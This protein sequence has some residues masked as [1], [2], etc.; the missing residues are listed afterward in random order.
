MADLLLN[1]STMKNLQLGV[2]II[3]LGAT[4][5]Q[6]SAFAAT[7]QTMSAHAN[8]N[9]RQCHLKTTSTESYLTATN[10]DCLDCHSSQ[11]SSQPDGMG[12][13]GN[14]A[15][16]RCLQC[17]SYHESG[18]VI[19]TRGS[20]DLAALKQIDTGHCRSCHNAGSSLQ[21]LS[22]AHLAA[23]TLYHEQAATLREISPSQ[24]CLNCHSNT[25]ATVWQLACDSNVLEFS[26]HSTHPIEVEVI[27]GQGEYA[28]RIRYEIDERVP[29]FDQTIQC[30][31]CHQL[32]S[33]TTD[34]LVN[35]GQPKDLCLGCHQF[36]NQPANQSDQLMATMVT[37]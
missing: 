36:Q 7:D 27:P 9:C 13:H 28:H 4:V 20:I 1:Q 5:A 23:A 34:L 10:S 22:D 8:P 25:S 2:I 3:L 18:V 24:A 21:S 29:L 26:E 30:Q 15:R 11:L 14:Q 19:T 31:T 16:D 17:H 32:A 37:Y 35:L 33:E 12:F 6:G